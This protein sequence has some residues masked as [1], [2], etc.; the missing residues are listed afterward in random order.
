MS[1]N[2]EAV[3]A[4]PEGSSAGFSLRGRRILLLSPDRWGSMHVSKHHYARALVDRGNEVF[5]LEP[6]KTGAARSVEVRRDAEVQSLHVVSHAAFLPLFL[7]FKARRAYEILLRRHVASLSKAVG[8][9]DV[10][11]CFDSNGYS[12]LRWFE[13]VVRIYHPVD[14]VA[15]GPHPRRLA[16]SADII[17]S[18]A[19]EILASFDGVA[20]PRY[21]L[22]HGL[23]TDFVARALNRRSY[24]RNSTAK[25]TVGYVGNLFKLQLD[26]PCFR[27]LI[28][29]HPEVQFH[30]WSPTSLSESNVAGYPT[31]EALA[32]VHYLQMQ[33]NVTLRGLVPPARLAWEIEDIDAFVYLNDIRSDQNQGS[34]S[35]KI[36]EYLS[37][38]RVVIASKTSMYA[39]SGLLEML[40]TTDNADFPALFSS[41][42]AR[43]DE[44]NAPERQ[45]QRIAFSLDNTYERQVQRIEDILRTHL[46]Q[47]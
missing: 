3:S 29:E 4:L 18:V 26:R 34:N 19:R 41:S 11:W 39:D 14:Q 44:L 28:E 20:T 23:G 9:I 47:P 10:V 5:F 15:A 16:R 7:R 46:A 36:L 43:L 37:T 31:G 32:F 21:L 27:Q 35:H 6:P 13:G 24:T 12:D 8:K 1:A 17:L 30:I 40:P 33:P 22:N 2:V 38:G 42:I 25:I 45:Q